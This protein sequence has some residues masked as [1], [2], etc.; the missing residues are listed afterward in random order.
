MEIQTTAIKEVVIVTPKVFQDSRG[1]FS[2]VYVKARFDSINEI[3]FLQDNQSLS[4]K[5]NT[6]RGLHFQKAPF[7]QA[8]LVRVICGSILDVAV[9]IRK[10]SPTYGKYVS[11]VLSAEN[12][13]QLLVPVGFAHGF[14][15]LEDN[16]IVCYKVSAQYDAQSEGGVIFDDEELGINWGVGRDTAIL[17]EKDLLLPSFSKLDAGF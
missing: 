8:K 5:K 7:A 2:E 9:D 10:N 11:A 13:A 17:S 1:H 12:A 4:V 15:T 3:E 16:T 6:V 14:V